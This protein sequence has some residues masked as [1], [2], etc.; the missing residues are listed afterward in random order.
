M[1]ILTGAERSKV[2]GSGS[3]SWHHSKIQNTNSSRQVYVFVG[4]GTLF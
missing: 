4:P 1:L 2:Q 3:L